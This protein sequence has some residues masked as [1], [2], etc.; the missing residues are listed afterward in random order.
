MELLAKKCKPTTNIIQVHIN[1]MNQLTAGPKFP[2][3]GYLAKR[4]G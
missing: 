2:K 1:Q 4:A 3:A